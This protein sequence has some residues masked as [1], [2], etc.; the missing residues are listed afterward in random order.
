MKKVYAVEVLVDEE[1]GNVDV[2]IVFAHRADAED[3]VKEHQ[4]MV[5]VWYSNDLI[6]MYSVREFGVF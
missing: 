4:Q 6:P 2:A 1:Y 5:K 3:Y